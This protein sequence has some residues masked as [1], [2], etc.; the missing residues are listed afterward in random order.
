MI[1]SGIAYAADNGNWQEYVYANDGFAI[2][3]PSKPMTET[4]TVNS[5]FGPVE[6]HFYSIPME[7]DSGFM[8]IAS[9]LHP[10]DTRTPQQVLENARDGAVASVNGK[11]LSQAPVSLDN[12]PGL[13]IEVDTGKYHS[14]IR[15]YFAGRILYQLMSIAPLGQPLPAETARFVDSFHFVQRL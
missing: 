14:R 4:S 2:S 11:L 10:S 7:N 6:M 12:K 5:P 15:Y 1:C 3:A 9:E 13:Q 8:A